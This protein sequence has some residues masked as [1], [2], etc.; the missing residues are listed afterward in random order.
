MIIYLIYLYL[1]LGLF[2]IINNKKIPKYYLGIL[3]F[4]TFKWIF[5]YRKCTVSWLE[6]YLRGVKKEEGYLNYYL[7]KIVD[8]RYDK[9]INII[10]LIC[11]FIIIYELIYKGKYKEMLMI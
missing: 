10:I 1:F 9:N 6:C 3:I 2:C 4:I 7:D 5:N 8:I 11:L